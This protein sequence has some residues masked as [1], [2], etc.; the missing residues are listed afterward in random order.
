MDDEGAKKS[1]VPE[2]KS[3]DYSVY[4]KRQF[5]TDDIFSL[6]KEILRTKKKQPSQATRPK[7]PKLSEVSTV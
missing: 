7:Q 2:D 4:S 1:K 6:P 3:D 5:L